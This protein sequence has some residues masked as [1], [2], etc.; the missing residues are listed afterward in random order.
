[1]FV[2]DVLEEWKTIDYKLIQEHGHELL[3]FVGDQPGEGR[4]V[5]RVSHSVPSLVVVPSELPG[6][7]ETV[8][9]I[10]AGYREMTGSLKNLS[11]SVD[12]SEELYKKEGLWQ[13]KFPDLPGKLLK[14]MSSPSWGWF[15]ACWPKEDNLVGSNDRDLHRISAL[16]DRLAQLST[17]VVRDAGMSTP[18]FFA[19]DDWMQFQEDS[20]GPKN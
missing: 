3:R 10:Q 7:D 6:W 16:L 5:G 19:P 18:V 20:L 14:L 2:G 4:G 12:E 13:R 9:R 17:S 1:M 8:L 11:W 15:V